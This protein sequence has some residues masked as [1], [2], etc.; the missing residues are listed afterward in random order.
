MVRVTVAPSSRR[1]RKRILKQTKGFFGDRKNH[2]RQSHN[3]VISAL[4]FNYKHRKL[5]KRDFRSLWITR[6]S[7]AAK[8]HG[9][10]YSK[11]IFGLKKGGLDFNRKILSEMALSDPEGFKAIADKAKLSLA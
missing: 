9:I 11:L 2:I 1:R 8:I 3:A 7:V 6:I 10:S 4:A 5:R